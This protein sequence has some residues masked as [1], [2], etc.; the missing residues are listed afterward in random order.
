MLSNNRV[1]KMIGEA[2]E[3]VPLS[4][5]KAEQRQIAF[6]KAITKIIGGGNADRLTP[7]VFDK[8]MTE[9]GEKIGQISKE[10]PIK[11]DEEFRASFLQTAR[12]ASKF[13]TSDVAK[14]VRNYVTELDRMTQKGVIDGDAFRKLNTKLGKQIRSTSNGDLKNALYGLQEKMH[15]ALE[16][17]ISSPEKLAELQDARYKYA[18]GKVIEPLVAK[19]KGGDI[20]PAGLMGRVTSDST[21][22]SM[23]ARGKGG[24]IGDLA[25]IG[26]AF[27]K[28]P[29]S[30][31]TGERI[32]AYSLLTGGAIAEPHTAAGIVGAANIY[33][34]LGPA[35]TKRAIKSRVTPYLIGDDK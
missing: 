15:D 18:I 20:S 29:P 31:G 30:S 8:A 25:K 34:R 2:L 6:N 17:N 33:N 24:E 35:I 19:A 27:L 7:D 16:K 23:M 9:S 4:G 11:A 14:I 22:K 3:Q 1:A 12:E 26:Q 28:E 32:G 10:T 21:K 5:S 13:E